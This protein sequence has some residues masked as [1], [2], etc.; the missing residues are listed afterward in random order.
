M[1]DMKG[2]I[3]EML[4][5]EELVV[6]KLLED[7]RLINELFA[8]CGEQE[9]RFIENSGL[10]FGA[11]LGVVQAVVWYGLQ[12]VF[13]K[14]ELWWF[15]PAAGALCGYVTNALALWL[16]FQPIEPR[17]YCGYRMH[18]R[19]LQR[20]REVS[21]MFAAISA[22]RVLTARNMWERIMFGPNR[23]YLD[24]IVGR[25]VKRAIDEHVAIIR[26][27][28][29][30]VVGTQT[31][32]AAKQQAA[33]LFLVEFPRCLPATYSYTEEAMGA[34]ERLSSKMQAL[35]SQDFE[36]VL[37]PV[38]EEDELKLI[39]VG[40]LLGMVAGVFQNGIFGV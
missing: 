13:D 37:H 36:R 26:P 35:S 31:F 20:Q 39:L 17:I 3:M 21:I 10:Y 24:A 25:H 11:G 9:F 32:V 18:G 7:K 16:I 23:H 30:L 40:G 15:L 14:S 38:F 1:L 5:L 33:E 34:E 27:F 29:P 2:N 8:R 12:C 19:F 28:I 6:E 4:D 22:E